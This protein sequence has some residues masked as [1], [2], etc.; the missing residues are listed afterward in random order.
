MLQ[1][2]ELGQSWKNKRAWQKGFP[3]EIFFARKGYM[4]VSVRKRIQGKTK[5]GIRMNITFKIRH[6][7]GESQEERESL[8]R[9]RQILNRQ[10][11]LRGNLIEMKH[12][13]G[14]KQCR[15][16]KNKENLHRSWYVSQSKDGKQRMRSV[17]NEQ[18]AKVKRWIS[19]YCD[20]K[21]L[22]TEL[23]QSN[24]EYIGKAEE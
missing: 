6:R 22:L 15:C 23:G 9:L 14:K 18:I 16:R 12:R 19:N 7:G 4:D 1:G 3:Q 13:C 11:F 10:G 21:H 5:R 20:V 24:W 8:S 17:P 2:I